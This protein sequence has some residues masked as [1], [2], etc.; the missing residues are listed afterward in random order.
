MS[1]ASPFDQTLRSP[2]SSRDFFDTREFVFGS[3]RFGGGKGQFLTAEK[4]IC[5]IC[6]FLQDSVAISEGSLNHIVKHRGLR[7]QDIAFR[8]VFVAF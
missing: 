4:C 5:R 1:V 7:I 2:K 6:W 3:S 8:Y